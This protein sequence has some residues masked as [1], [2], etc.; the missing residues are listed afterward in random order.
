MNKT[1]KQFF[2]ELKKY[3]EKNDIFAM[4]VIYGF[5]AIFIAGIIVAIFG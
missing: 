4:I 3:D 1:L 2:Y 5:I